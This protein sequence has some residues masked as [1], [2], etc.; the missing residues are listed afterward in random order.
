MIPEKLY[1]QIHASMPI[2]CVDLVIID[3]NGKF[4]LV[5]RSN[6][7]AKGKWWLVGGRANKGETLRQAAARKAKQELGTKVILEEA[8]GFDETMFKTG[9]FGSPTHT[10]NIVFSARL[11]GKSI[12]LDSQAEKYA[13]FDRID[14]K[15]PAYVKKF[16]LLA[17][18][19]KRKPKN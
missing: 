1:K 13:W 14:P 7:P 5:K 9:P 8:L 2:L 3:K 17:S 12:K 19:K 11:S 6:E 15:W 18:P 4:L 10:V 16:L